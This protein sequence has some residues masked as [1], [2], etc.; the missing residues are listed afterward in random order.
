MEN[1]RGHIFIPLLE[2]SD[3]EKMSEANIDTL[4]GD[5]H[6]SVAVV[7]QKRDGINMRPSLP[8]LAKTRR[9]TLAS[10]RKRLAT[11]NKLRSLRGSRAPSSP[12]KLKFAGTP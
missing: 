3:Q 5:A 11:I 8:L 4:L 7:P 9:I 12:H 10:R 1:R 2:R 6:L